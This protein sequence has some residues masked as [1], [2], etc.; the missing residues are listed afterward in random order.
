MSRIAARFD[1]LKAEGRKALIPF[2]TAGDPQPGVTVPLMHQMVIAGAD[3]IELGVPFS[4]PMADGPVI[5]KAN[6]R[7][8]QYHVTLHDVL[9][10]VASFR[11][12]DDDTPVLLM[13]YLNPIEAMGYEAV[14]EACV[15]AGVDGLLIVDMP[16]EEAAEFNKMLYQ[17]N[18]DP[19]YL[20]AP[21]STEERMDLVSNAARGFVYYVSIRGVTGAAALDYDEINQR[22]RMIRKHTSLPVGVGFG[23]NS[24]ESAIKIGQHADAVIIGSAIVN[25][26][27]QGRGDPE[28]ILTSID[29]FLRDIRQA[30]DASSEQ[31]RT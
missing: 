7:A 5:Q 17:R 3:L 27:E 16:P 25:R 1:H 12:Q 6:Q 18:I 2:V 8:L 26:V 20:L 31:E 23:I 11:E 22:I 19:V 21:T 29:T 15:A 9:D 28:A 13:G 4:D 14:A 24:P 30:L 10:M